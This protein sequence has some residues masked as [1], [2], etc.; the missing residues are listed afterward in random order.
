MIDL[1]RY[2]PPLGLKWGNV[3]RCYSRPMPRWVVLGHPPAR[4]SSEK[5]SS[6][7]MRRKKAKPEQDCRR[8][9]ATTSTKA[10][11]I[12]CGQLSKSDGCSGV[13]SRAGSGNSNSKSY[14]LPDGRGIINQATRNSPRAAKRRKKVKA[15]QDCPRGHATTGTAITINMGSPAR[16]EAAPAPYPAPCPE[17]MTRSPLSILTEGTSHNF[18]Q[19]TA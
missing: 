8:S 13:I 19:V 17:T 18:T 15:E 14:E 16:V 6:T 11:T 2:P 5:L 12:K 3:W 9:R 7:A 10:T 1:L 4:P